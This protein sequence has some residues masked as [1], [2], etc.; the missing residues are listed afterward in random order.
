MERLSVSTK[1]K[2]TLKSVAPSVYKLA[3][4]GSVHITGSTQETKRSNP[5][6]GA[7]GEMTAEV[8]VLLC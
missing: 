1:R 8:Q 4:G 3:Y 7:W 2:L 5:S 6:D